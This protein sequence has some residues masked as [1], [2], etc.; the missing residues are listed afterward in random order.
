MGTTLT[1]RIPDDLAREIARISREERLDKSAVARRLLE[2][3]V[4][5]YRLDRALE[6]YQRGELTLRAA[7][8]S[9]QLPLRAFLD[10]LGRRGV[11]LQYAMEDLEEDLGR[12]QHA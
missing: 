9:G 10:E 2:Q 8:R 7:A 1:A 6:R 11:P 4:R 12:A 5:T 3:G